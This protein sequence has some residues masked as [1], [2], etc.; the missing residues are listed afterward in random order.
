[1]VFAPPEAQSGGMTSSRQ[2]EPTV[3]G[4]VSYFS[5]Y[6]MPATRPSDGPGLMLRARVWMKSNDLDAALAGGTNPAK[7][8]E[9]AHRAIQLA[10]RKARNRM[11]DAITRLVD[12][13]DEERAAIVTP[14]PPFTP[15]QVRAN[16]SLLLEL[17]EELRGPG[18]AALAGLALTSLMLEDGRGP[19]TTRGDPATLERALQTALSALRQDPHPGRTT[20]STIGASA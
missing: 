2:N 19:L 15:Q 7:S 20:R 11:A 13:A 4:W 18:A 6:Y 1:M 14:G 16:R 17:A 8:E 5:P 12:I 9:L 3:P 10:D